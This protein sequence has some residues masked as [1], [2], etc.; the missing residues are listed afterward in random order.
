MIGY[1]REQWASIVIV[2]GAMYALFAFGVEPALD[3]RAELAIEAR[4]AS[5]ELSR[6]GVSTTEPGQEESAS[7]VARLLGYRFGEDTLIGEQ[8]R[9]HALASDAG[10]RIGNVEPDPRAS[11]D[12]FGPLVL[13]VGQVRVSATGTYDQ[14]AVFLTSIDR[15]PMATVE[16]FVLREGDEAGSVQL[17]LTLSTTSVTDNETTL[18][19]GEMR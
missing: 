1:I 19:D 15:A 16:E 2:F 3:H 12:A 6:L 8:N 18:A 17:S 10:L 7:R 9:I 11:A 5:E 4:A 13:R 14:I